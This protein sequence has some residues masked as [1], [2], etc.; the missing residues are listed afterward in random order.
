MYSPFEHLVGLAD[1]F[2]GVLDLFRSGLA[3]ALDPLKSED[4][5]VLSEEL[6]DSM[7]SSV[8]RA[9][10]LRLQQ[11]VAALDQDWARL[12][13]LVRGRVVA[14]AVRS[15]SAPPS[16]EVSSKLEQRLRVGAV[17][18]MA[19]SKR[20]AAEEG[21]YRAGAVLT[22]KDRRVADQTARIQAAA[23][24]GEYER[25]AKSA[26]N[27]ANDVVARGLRQGLT[28]DQIHAALAT[29]L[30]AQQERRA[31]SY[32]R[33]VAGLQVARSRSYGVL[34]TYQANGVA[35]FRFQATI[36]H[37]TSA[38]CRFLHGRVFSVS[39]AL[40]RYEVAADASPEEATQ[41]L[42]WM[43]HGKDPDGGEHLY[44]RGAEGAKV[45]VAQ[46][47]AGG[48]AFLSRLGNGRLEGLG[49]STPPLHPHCR[50]RIVAVGSSASVSVP[51]VVWGP[52]LPAKV[53]DIKLPL[54][55]DYSN[56]SAAQLEARARAYATPE[57]LAAAAVGPEEGV[58]RAW[59][60]IPTND[61]G[62]PRFSQGALD[63]AR[64]EASAGTLPKPVLVLKDGLLHPATDED[65]LRAAA[66]SAVSR[67]K[68]S[69]VQ[70]PARVIR[71]AHVTDPKAFARAMADALEA[72]D[73]VSVR[74]LMRD[75]I[76]GKGLRSRDV[77][78]V[79]DLPQAFEYAPFVGPDGK[80][81]RAMHRWSGQI[82]VREDIA[83]HVTT[84]YR[85]VARG[86]SLSYEEIRAINTLMHEELHGH[87]PREKKAYAGYGVAV[88]EVGT[89]ML[90]RRFSAQLRGLNPVRLKEGHAYAYP[91]PTRLEDGSYTYRS[92]PD[93]RKRSYD[94]MI[95]PMLEHV[96]RVQ[97]GD[98]GRT[99]ER[100]ADAYQQLR[101]D[102]GRTYPTAR[103]H[104]EGL[105][106]ALGMTEEQKARFIA[107]LENDPRLRRDA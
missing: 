55:R 73:Q 28:R 22:D 44:V 47:A 15:L 58:G 20:S 52:S 95:G 77:S 60:K 67:D 54:A 31:E 25:R 81:P 107:A 100:L 62:Q 46:A 30:E 12:S 39:T 9:D 87:S 78:G 91:T 89:E 42:P 104:A 65:A 48:G 14:Q 83:P 51:A 18:A 66:Y 57:A 82:V 63:S 6:A 33:L 88:E 37:R 2:G 36:D 53:A 76:A 16:P 68:T 56:V 3:K 34:S 94:G 8:R 40:A 26:Q 86:E 97:G 75:H 103:A 29:E 41:L 98:P 106:D 23:Y 38:Q 74:G 102:H 4:F 85:K 43:G 99:A 70:I 32:H 80:G 50:S 64:R 45:V 79:G 21:G 69:G 72:G 11:A 27:L 84:A 1:A 13:P 17:G 7:G 19:R 10:R 101:G 92:P 49:V 71:P 90:A 24:P 35:Q 105:A 93:A 59:I 61:K 5:L 96:H